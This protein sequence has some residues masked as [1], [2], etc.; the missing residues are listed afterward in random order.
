VT[1]RPRGARAPSRLRTTFILTITLAY[2]A[3]GFLAVIAFRMSARGLDTAFAGRF[4]VTQALLE[5]NRVLSRIEREVALALKLADD[6]I[7]T[8]WAA[9]EN[10][11]PTRALAME[12]LESYRRAFTDHSFFIALEGSKHY[13]IHNS[14][15]LA[16]RV[17]VTTLSPDNASDGWYFEAM[18][19]VEK[20]ALNVDYDR[21]IRAAKV[22]IN[23]VMRDAR[24]AKIGLCGSG[25]DISDFLKSV[26]QP[27]DS[28]ALTILVDRAGVIAAHPNVAYV[29]RNANA[30]GTEAKLTIY[31]LLARAGEGEALRSAMRDLAAGGNEV[32]SLPLTVEGR[33]YLAAVSFL[34]SIDWYNIVLVDTARVLRFTDLLPLAL[35]IVASLLLVLLA[36]ALMLSRVVLRPLSAL[37]S[38]SRQISEGRYGVQI[39]VTRADEIG[40]LTG[41]FNAMSATVRDT[42]AGLETRVEERTRELTRSHRALEESQRLIMESLVYAQRLQNGILPGKEALARTLPEHLVIYLP[43]DLVGG[44]IYLVR[45]FSDRLV[46]AV[47]DCMGHGVPGAFM[48]MTVHA[49]LNHILDAVCS[50]EPARIIAELDNALRETLHREEADLRLDSGLDIAVCVCWTEKGTAAFAGAGLPLFVWNGHEVAE[51]KGDTR[52][53]GYR[54][55]R[56]GAG[57]LRSGP[58]WTDHSV[59][60]ERDTALYLATDGFLDQAGGDKGFGFGRRRF[61]EMI[62]SYAALTMTEQERAFR[63]TLGAYR[64]AVSQRDDITILGFRPGKGGNG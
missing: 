3:I 11:S 8:R 9:A 17:E 62:G 36:V 10:D 63:S 15:S 54:S 35:T 25:I 18:R 21:L 27:A 45:R 24:G 53:V 32:V 51:V 31:D 28:N 60:V 52:K 23:A 29:L 57:R 22:W 46:A 41:A 33:P 7:V 58:A 56:T 13:Y 16:D 6:P 2:V 48:T 42:T 43:R 64:G 37:A 59:A 47:I 20:F 44:D 34:G 5:K 55:R 39:P 12:Q 1:I 61:V 50:D 4:A 19:T 30:K 49:V 38:A 40:Q 26:L 14:A